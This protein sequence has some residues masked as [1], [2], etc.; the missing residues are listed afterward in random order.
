[1]QKNEKL[2]SKG[3]VGIIGKTKSLV[4]KLHQVL[5]HIRI[6]GSLVKIKSVNVRE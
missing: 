2:T 1:M 6:P 4:R 3:K 5:G